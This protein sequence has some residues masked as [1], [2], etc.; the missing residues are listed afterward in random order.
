MTHCIWMRLGNIVTTRLELVV[1][2]MVLIC[3]SL[4]TLHLF[5]PP[6]T[7][8]LWEARAAVLLEDGDYENAYDAYRRLTGLDGKNTATAQVGLES[9]LD[10]WRMGIRELMFECK[11]DEVIE[12]YRLMDKYIELRPIVKDVRVDLDAFRTVYFGNSYIYRY[13][14]DYCMYSIR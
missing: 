4:A 2:V 14:N 3:L 1:W 7:I 11:F 6:P 5:Q 10:A 13:G 8:K 9:V 12:N